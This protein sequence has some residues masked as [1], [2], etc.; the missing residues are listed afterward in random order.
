MLPSNLLNVLDIDSAAVARAKTRQSRFWKGLGNDVPTLVL[1]GAPLTPAQE[2]ALPPANYKEALESPERMLLNELR[3]AA[4][5]S[6]ARSD[7]VPTLRAN[8]GTAVTLSVFGLEQEIFPDKMP[9]LLRHLTK[10]EASRLTPDDILPKGSVARALEFV[11]YFKSVLGDLVPVY[12]YDTQGP[13][14]L[15][16][17]ILGD[18][19]YYEVADDPPYVHFLCELCTELYLRATSWHKEITGEGPTEM[20]HG[21]GLYSDSFGVR[22]CD[23]VSC[24]LSR[25]MLEEFSMPYASRVAQAFGGAFYH[26]CGRND[27]LTA[28]LLER[29]E[30][31]VINFG[32]V[33]SRPYDHDFETEMEKFAAAGH[34]YYGGW[35]RFPDERRADY[36]RRLHRCAKAGVLLPPLSLHTVLAP[37]EGLTDA[38]SVLAFWASI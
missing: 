9:W 13:L 33:P 5:S 31:K 19:F 20:V 22:I 14:G 15:V 27:G 1:Y 25:A 32:H 6:N 12:V 36:L 34:R 38:A 3:G 37:E 24:L 30:F 35:P 18:E 26:Y 2:A 4:G 8:F 10:A 29:P 28:S 21:G 11:R 16:Q 7:S 23:D 17:S